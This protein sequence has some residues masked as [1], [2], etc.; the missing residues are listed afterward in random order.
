M[1]AFGIILIKFIL[2]NCILRLSFFRQL[3]RITIVTKDLISFYLV[4]SLRTHAKSSKTRW[5]GCRGA[6]AMQIVFSGSRTAKEVFYAS[7][8]P[9]FNERREYLTT[10]LLREAVEK[11]SHR[12]HKML[13]PKNSCTFNLSPSVFLMFVLTQTDLETLLLQATFPNIFK[14]HIVFIL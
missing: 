12:L 11:N 8:L 14:I 2:Q 10:K 1:T 6:Y 13:P 4:Q 9:T 7:N 3:K 5:R